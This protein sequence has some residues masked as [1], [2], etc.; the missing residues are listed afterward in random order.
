M[1][2]RTAFYY[3]FMVTA[4]GL[5]IFFILRV[6]NQLPAPALPFSTQSGFQIA[7]HLAGAS[8]YSFSASVESSL[9]RPLRFSL[10]LLSRPGRAEPL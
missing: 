5:G 6:G 2:K 10:F 7:P 4:V 3:F 8:D 9:R 1:M